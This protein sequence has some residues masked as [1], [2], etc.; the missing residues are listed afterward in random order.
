LRETEHYDEDSE[1][2]CDGMLQNKIPG[3][4]K[5]AEKLSVDWRFDQRKINQGRA[6]WT[7]SDVIKDTSGRRPDH[8]DYD[9][10]TIFIPEEVWKNLS[11][12]KI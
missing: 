5:P 1:I 6:W 11:S 4:K 10:S 3:Y 9:K 12:S 7:K 2:F 8:P